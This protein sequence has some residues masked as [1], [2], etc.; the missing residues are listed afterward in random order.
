[1]INKK[2][3]GYNP[4][5]LQAWLSWYAGCSLPEYFGAQKGELG[6]ELQQVPQEYSKLLKWFQGKNF[7]SYLELGIGRGGS[8]LL[9]VMFQKDIDMAVA[10]DNSEYWKNDQKKSIKEKIEWLKEQDKYVSFYDCS[11]DDFFANKIGLSIKFDCIFIDADHSYEGVKKDFDNALR[12]IKRDGYIIFHDIASSQCPGVVQIWEEVKDKYKMVETFIHGSNCGIGI[13]KVEAPDE[14]SH[15]SDTSRLNN[16]THGKY[17]MVLIETRDRD[18]KA[19]FQ[20]HKRFISDEWKEYI[21]TDIHD[22]SIAKLN[23]LLTSYE[24]WD[25]LPFEKVLIIQPD[26]QLLRA[27]IEEFMEWDFVGA[28]HTFCEWTANGGLSLRTVSVMKEICR[29]HKYEGEAVHGNEDIF[30]TNILH[31]EPQYGKL[32]P[33]TVNEKFSCESI[34]KLGTLGEHAANKYL[35]KDEYQQVITQYK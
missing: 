9:N 28:P 3:M 1:M 23:Q 5:M 15:T 30:F 18:L 16:D 35:T 26:S 33:R 4:K 11:T 29:T 31:Y 24:F 2:I 22:F 21:K 10:V 27:G 13:I 8:F 7:H 6:L 19:I 34:F 25:S 17:G 12:H 14:C 20:K 32:A